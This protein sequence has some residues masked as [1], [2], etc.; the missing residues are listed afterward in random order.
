MMK[1]VAAPTA[2]TMRP[3]I[4][5]P[6]L[7]A[8][9]KPTALAITAGAICDRGTWSP[10]EACQAG[11]NRAAPQPTR[12]VSASRSEGVTRSASA[13]A[14]SPAEAASASVCANNMM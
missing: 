13:T 2:A 14:A 6:R 1:A 11:A 3:P 9:L 10:I 4:A 8:R 7:R 12:N 5:G